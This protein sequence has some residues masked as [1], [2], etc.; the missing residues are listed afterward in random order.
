MSNVVLVVIVND[1]RG[2]HLLEQQ[3]VH[4]C[5]RARGRASVRTCNNNSSSSKTSPGTPSPFPHLP[6]SLHMHMRTRTHACVMH[7]VCACSAMP[8]LLGERHMDA[9]VVQ[10]DLAVDDSALAAYCDTPH[11]PRDRLLQEAC[12]CSIRQR[13]RVMHVNLPAVAGP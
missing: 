13:P 10:I 2:T 11:M 5:V 3:C 8:D 12:W 4:V 1:T 6:P 9:H 7:R